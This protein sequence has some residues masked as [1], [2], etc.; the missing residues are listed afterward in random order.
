MPPLLEVKNLTK[1]FTYK[2]GIFKKE[3]FYVFKNLNF[4]VE[5]K[6][7]F[8]IAG[9]T[10]AG[11][12]TLAKIIAGLL[13]FDEGDVNWNPDFIKNIKKDVKYIPQN[14]LASLNPRLKIKE[15]LTEPLRVWYKNQKSEWTDIMKKSL[16]KVNLPLEILDSYPFQLSGGQR[17]RVCLAL[18]LE[19]DPKVLI[20]DEIISFLDLNLQVQ[21]LKLLKNLNETFNLTIIL[22][23]HNIQILN[24]FCDKIF[25]L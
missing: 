3:R 6:S 2:K 20:C 14:P 12:S 17:Q 16:E 18:A 23:S 9:K 15:L 10:G 4:S 19:C 11:K 25:S 5:F 22:I 8:G 7:I 24:S 1:S 21:I 13:P